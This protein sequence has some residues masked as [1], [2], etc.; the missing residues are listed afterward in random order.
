MALKKSSEQIQISTTVDSAGIGVFS[1]NP[2]DLQLNA[3]DNEVFVV[4]AIKI[5]FLT[6]VDCNLT[7]PGQ[8]NDEDRVALTTTRPSAMPSIGDNNCLGTAYRMSNYGVA[9]AG[10][11]PHDL[12]AVNVYEQH[13]TDNPDARLD[14]I[15]IIATSD[16]F[17][18]TE[19]TQLNTQ[20]YGVR[21]YGYRAKAD[22]ATYAALVQSEVLSS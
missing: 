9:Q 19:T 1:A 17:I 13:S 12:L 3:L 22:A 10:T 6:A 18:S 7:T 14:R 11:P 2:V 16:F 21:L 5:D 4:T 20:S 15:G 8:F